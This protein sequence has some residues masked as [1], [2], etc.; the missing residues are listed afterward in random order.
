MSDR[1]LVE[2]IEERNEYGPWWTLTIERSAAGPPG[3]LITIRNQDYE[4]KIWDEQTTIIVHDAVS[5]LEPVIT[6]AKGQ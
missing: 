5:V 2:Y 4:K 3:V 6:W 1:R